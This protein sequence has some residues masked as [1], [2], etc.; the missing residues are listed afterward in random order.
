MPHTKFFRLIPSLR[1]AFYQQ[2]GTTHYGH[3]RIRRAGGGRWLAATAAGGLLLALL[4]HGARPPSAEQELAWLTRL[5]DAEDPGAQLQLA[6]AY[7]D[8]RYGLAP[9][10]KT[11]QYWLERAARNGQAYAADL[12][13]G[14]QPGGKAFAPGG[15]TETAPSS[16]SSRLDTLATQLDSP[17]LIT[18]S[19]IGKILSMIS[20]GAQSSDALQYQAQSGD[21]V[22]EFQLATRYRDGAWSVNRDPA[23][24]LFWLR[25]S[26]RA[27]NPIAMRTLAEVYR[28]GELGVA[29]DTEEAV[30]WERR[31][32]AASR[33]PS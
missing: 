8:G 9:D 17:T 7:R 33:Q 21:P 1:A 25:R 10:V 30:W 22:A 13:A 28:T 11:G 32:E 29:R 18:V 20:T 4:V 6:L 31:A 26:A 27:G 14:N 16:G 15:N 24:A 3:L 5:A 23:K 19:A 2:P 12:I